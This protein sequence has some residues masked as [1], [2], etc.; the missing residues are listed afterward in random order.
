[1]G[2]LIL[3]TIPEASKQ[4][5]VSFV[6]FVM[7]SNVKNIAP[8]LEYRFLELGKRY[9]WARYPPFYGSQLSTE[10]I[11]LWDITNVKIRCYYPA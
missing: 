10:I 11:T 5:P 6:P 9:C 1:M 3:T 4:F 7:H 8:D 2:G